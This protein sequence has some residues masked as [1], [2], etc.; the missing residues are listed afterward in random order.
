MNKTPCKQCGHFM[1]EHYDNGQCLFA[2]C[3]CV[4]NIEPH[5]ER[6]EVDIETSTLREDV[7]IKEG[8]ILSLSN[9]IQMMQ[10]YTHKDMDDY[11]DHRFKVIEL[12]SERILD[13]IDQEKLNSYKD[14]YIAGGLDEIL[15]HEKAE[16]KL[17]K[18]LDKD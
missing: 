1:G 18:Y 4:P 16:N 10:E 3:V 11:Y 12:Y 17:M 7:G 15:R 2:R 8:V 5:M 6:Q 9:A 13:L 14:G